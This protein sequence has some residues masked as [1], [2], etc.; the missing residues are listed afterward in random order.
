M[1]TNC[2][3]LHF[4]FFLDF[5]RRVWKEWYQVIPTDK[6]INNG[7][8]AKL[9][10]AHTATKKQEKKSAKIVLPVVPEE[11]EDD[12]T[13]A[14]NDLKISSER[15][16]SIEEIEDKDEEIGENSEFEDSEIEHED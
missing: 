14:A 13:N 8:G 5:V 1:Y 10:S 11:S 16:K 12:E 7:V 3:S 4:D 9:R 2:V 15:E 6:A